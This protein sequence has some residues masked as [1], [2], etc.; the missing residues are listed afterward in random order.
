M[1]LVLIYFTKFCKGS[2]QW[3]RV[4]VLSWVMGEGIYREF[5]MKSELGSAGAL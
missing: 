3:E 1:H 5:M 2:K 4:R